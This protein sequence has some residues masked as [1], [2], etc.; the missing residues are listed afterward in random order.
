MSQARRQEIL[1]SDV[2]LCVRQ[3]IALELEWDCSSREGRPV[4]N[5]ESEF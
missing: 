1:I 2:C 5:D 4:A 3:L